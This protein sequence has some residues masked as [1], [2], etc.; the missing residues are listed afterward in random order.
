[1]STTREVARDLLGS[2]ATDENM[3]MAVKWIDN[4]YKELV[5][6]VRFNHLRRIGEL[7]TAALVNDHTVSVTEASTSV[8]GSSTTWATSPAAF[9]TTTNPFWAFRARSAWYSVDV[10]T[11][12]TALT[13]AT[14]FSEDTVS[15]GTYSLVKRYH[16]LD[17]NARWLGQFIHPR[18]GTILGEPMSLAELDSIDASRTIAGSYPLH[19]AYVGTTES[20]ATV[21][22]GLVMVELYPYTRD[23]ELIKYVYWDIPGTLDVNTTIPPQIDG[24]IL[25]EGAYI[26]YCRW[27]MAKREM[28]GKLES[29][30]FWRNEMNAAKTKWEYLIGQATRTDR[31][32]DDVSFI[33]QRDS[34]G[35]Q[36]GVGD[37]V[38]ARGHWLAGYTRP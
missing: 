3:L 20:T 24:Y 13:L 30:T 4:K 25:K 35:V 12:N 6:R 1:M 18:L 8:T 31:A 9:A 10:V 23:A 33:L 7:R 27:M 28:E 11:S 26:D 14:A 15:G 19:V 29:A 17:S 2:M 38:T 21:G 5:S 22:Y 16:V 36:Q 34:G 32:A 37:V